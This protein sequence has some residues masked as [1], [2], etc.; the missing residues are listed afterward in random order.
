[1]S[2][3]REGSRRGS[4]DLP[5]EKPTKRFAA[6]FNRAFL[7]PEK[8]HSTKKGAHGYNRSD[9]KEEIRRIREELDGDETS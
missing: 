5:P 3:I 9:E 8:F 4:E 1:M 6:K 2:H 7:P